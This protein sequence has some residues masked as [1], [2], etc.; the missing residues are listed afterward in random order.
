MIA[1]RISDGAVVDPHGGARDIEA[2]RI[3][4]VSP[5]TFVEDPLRLLRAA[6]FAARF[7]YELS[8]GARE[9]MIAAASLV[10]TVSP[11][12]VCDEL[13]KLFGSPRRPSVGIAAF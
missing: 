2:G 12:R 9:G 4:I 7:G 6:Q 1:R 11:E 10:R 3:D 13:L 8:D 5:K